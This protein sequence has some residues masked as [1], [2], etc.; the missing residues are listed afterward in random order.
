VENFI[1]EVIKKGKKEIYIGLAIVVV[2]IV[3]TIITIS[4]AVYQVK[5]IVSGQKQVKHMYSLAKQ[6]DTVRPKIDESIEIG[7]YIEA[8]FYDSK[9]VKDDISRELSASGLVVMQISISE[10]DQQQR[11]SLPNS[12]VLNVN[13]VGTISL[14]DVDGFIF[15]ISARPKIWQINKLQI[16]PKISPTEL[17]AKLDQYY[18]QRDYDRINNF[19]SQVSDVNLKAIP[20]EVTLQISVLAQS[21]S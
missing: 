3:T 19:L 21:S 8:V 7:R 2:V 14:E 17:I 18:Q 4:F 5:G 15:A 10:P 9:K 13:V 11:L 6:V 16:T 20:V 1:A 12:Q